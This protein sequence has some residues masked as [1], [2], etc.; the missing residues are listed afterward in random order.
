MSYCSTVI[1]VQP[2]QR[3]RLTNAVRL[4]YRL[5]CGNLERPWSADLIAANPK[6]AHGPSPFP[7]GLEDCLAGVKYLHENKTSLKISSIV[8][9]GESAG[10]NLATAV[11]MYASRKGFRGMIDGVYAMCP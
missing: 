8:T 11:A 4:R 7:L 6:V 3:A 10:G 1:R 9:S 5:S 2:P